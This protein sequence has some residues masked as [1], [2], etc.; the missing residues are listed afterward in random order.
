MGTSYPAESANDALIINFKLKA[1]TNPNI[2]R[3]TKS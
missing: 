2:L 3:K 1:P